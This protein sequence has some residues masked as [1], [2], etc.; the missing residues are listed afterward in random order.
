M[1]TGRWS[2]QEIAALDAVLSRPRMQGDLG[3]LAQKLDRNPASLYQLVHKRAAVLGLAKSA[4]RAWP[5]CDAMIDD[6]PLSYTKRFE[7]ILRE[8]S[9]V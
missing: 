5:T 6:G 9:P 2:P 1:K 7:R 3:R 8:A 4:K